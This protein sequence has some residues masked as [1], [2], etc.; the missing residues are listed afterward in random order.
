MDTPPTP[1]T[2]TIPLTTFLDLYIGRRFAGHVVVD[3]KEPDTAIVLA[4][5]RLAD[6][7]E[8]LLHIESPG[9][10]DNEQTLTRVWYKRDWEVEERRLQ[11]KQHKSIERVAAWNKKKENIDNLAAEIRKKFS[12]LDE[13]VVMEMALRIVDGGNQEAANQFGV[14]IE[15]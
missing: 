1:T 2:V 11:L 13:K 4:T 14:T 10:L 15:K 3:Q 9:E 7:Q 6:P 8:N 12:V 5:L